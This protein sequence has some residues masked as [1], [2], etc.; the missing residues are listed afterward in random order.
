MKTSKNIRIEVVTY[1]KNHIVTLR[2]EVIKAQN[3]N[4]KSYVPN[5]GKA[6]I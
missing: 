2:A 1:S 6:S 4:R 3:L 5:K